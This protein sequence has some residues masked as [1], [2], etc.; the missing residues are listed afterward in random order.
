[1]RPNVRRTAMAIVISLLLFPAIS[2]CVGM[3]AKFDAVVVES[4][5]MEWML[6]KGLAAAGILSGDEIQAIINIGDLIEKINKADDLMEKG[7]REKDVASME[8]AMK[9][10]PGD[11]TYQDS[12]A[13]LALEKGNL[14]LYQRHQNELLTKFS[15][16]SSSPAAQRYFKQDLAE[17]EA[18][19][20]A[21]SGKWTNGR[22]CAAVYD[23][24]IAN[25]KARPVAT[26]SMADQSALSG[27]T[28]LRSQC[29]PE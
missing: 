21:N 15:K 6:F 28:S 23:G 16:D 14:A 22:Q 18:I 24:L 25:Y 19:H 3:D 29:P 20:R 11:W 26:I 9:L 17:K 13:N 8:E 12:L 10:R 2:G 1:M 27:Y 7:R 4:F 5:A